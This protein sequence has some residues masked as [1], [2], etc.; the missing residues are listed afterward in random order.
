MQVKKELRFGKILGKRNQD[1][2]DEKEFTVK[3]VRFQIDDNS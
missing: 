3:R 1:M 2:P